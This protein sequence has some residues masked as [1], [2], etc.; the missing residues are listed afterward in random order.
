MIQLIG[1]PIDGAYIR[2]R[3][4]IDDGE[5]YTFR[6]RGVA[7]TYEPHKPPSH[8][9]LGVFIAGTYRHAR[10]EYERSGLGELPVP[11]IV[12]HDGDDNRRASGA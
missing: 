3:E 9:G 2:D 1:G 10:T 5:P 7:Y 8:M 12:F 6:D 11:L 4:W